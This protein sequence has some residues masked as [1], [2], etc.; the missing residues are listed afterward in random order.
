M[1]RRFRYA[2][3]SAIQRGYFRIAPDGRTLAFMQPF[4]RR[5]NIYI[6][7]LAGGETRR[8]TNETARDIS[9]HFW[10]GPQRLVYLKDFAGDENFHLVAATVDGSG[11]KD[12]TPFDGVRAQII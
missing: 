3:S 2:T 8:L 10:K 12:L 4:E 11:V 5:M 6:Q 7:P 9:D 1:P